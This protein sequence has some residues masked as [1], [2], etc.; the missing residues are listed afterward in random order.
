MR[1]K[2]LFMIL[3]FGTTFSIASA[4][5][6]VATKGPSV[7][8]RVKNAVALSVAR[9]QARWTGKNVRMKNG[10]LVLPGGETVTKGVPS[11]RGFVGGGASSG[12]IGGNSG[13]G[14]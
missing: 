5:D 3:V 12:N 7:W 13:V 8:N 14:L 10:T 6:R 11:D 9:K 2:T 4:A 1:T